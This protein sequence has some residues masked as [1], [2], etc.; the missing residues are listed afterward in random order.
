MKRFA[1]MKR[2][3]VQQIILTV[4]KVMAIIKIY[5]KKEMYLSKP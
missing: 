3:K 2:S 5:D 4:K 1:I